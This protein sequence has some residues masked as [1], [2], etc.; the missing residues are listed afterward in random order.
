MSNNNLAGIGAG[1]DSLPARFL[2]EPS[3]FGGS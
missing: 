1:S 3:T 2:D